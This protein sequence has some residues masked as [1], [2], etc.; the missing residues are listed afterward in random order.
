MKKSD[1]ILEGFEDLEIST[2]IVIRAALKRKV[3]IEILN[4]KSHFLKLE[5]N[6]HVEIIKEASK[7]SKDSYISFLIMEDKQ[8]SKYMLNR[9]GIKVPDGELF[10]DFNKA[11]DHIKKMDNK[12]V[13]IKPN[14]TNFGIGVFVFK[15]QASMEEYE[16]A[17]KNAFKHDDSIII[18]E[19][20][21]GQEYRFLVINNQCIAVCN[22]LPAN[23]IGD[24]HKNILELIQKKNKDIRR[25]KGH[26]T[27]LEIIEIDD[28]VEAWLKRKKLSLD[29]VPDK[30]VQVFL[31]S[32]SNISTGGDSIDITDE[33]HP[34]FL[35]IARRSAESVDAKICGV[36]IMTTDPTTHPDDTNYAV[37]EI[38]FNPVLYIHEFPYIGKQRHIGEHMMDLLGFE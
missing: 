10:T 6:N 37:I 24:G 32:N 25:G 30:N 12:P 27:P 38:N 21:A 14:S 8:V 34:E 15:T 7:T 23:V 31:R 28:I 4:R 26:V 17:I 19:F 18:E 22:R 35:E 13:V 3:N 33:I 16:Y 1:F 20:I 29:F 36:D 9:V 5:K 2:Q 11:R